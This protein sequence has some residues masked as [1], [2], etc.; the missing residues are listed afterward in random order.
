M[1]VVLR[2]SHL[3]SHI[4][5]ASAHLPFSIPKYTHLQI[6]A[7]LSP[8][9]TLFPEILQL[10][11]RNSSSS[12][13][14]GC[15]IIDQF[16]PSTDQCSLQINPIERHEVI[17]SLLKTIKRGQCTSLK[18]FLSL[19]SLSSLVKIMKSFGNCRSAVLFFKF[20]LP[21]SSEAFIRSSCIVALLLA[22]DS[23]RSLAQD[24]ISCVIT[25]IGQNRGSEVLDLMWRDHRAYVTEFCVLDIVFRAFLHAGAVSSAMQVLTRIR[26]RGLKP[27]ASSISILIKLLY[28]RGEFSTVW[29]LFRDMLRKGPR[30]SNRTFNTMVLGFCRRGDIRRGESLLQVMCKFGCKP[31]IYT[32]NIVINAHCVYGRSSDAFELLNSMIDMRCSPNTVTFNTLLKALCKEGNMQEAR[33]FFKEMCEEGIAPNQFAYNILIDGYAKAGEMDVANLVYVEMK[34]KGFTPDC[35]T[36]NILVS[37]HCKF[38]KQEDGDRLLQDVLVTDVLPDHSALDLFITRLCW[39]G[40]LDDAVGLLLHKIK[41]DLGLYLQLQRAIPCSWAYVREEDCK[42]L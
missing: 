16:L 23:L 26:E 11:A 40:R 30:P 20:A 2:R 4:W 39:E 22:V 42:R 9:K 29:D 31:D 25:R 12:S 35:F 41:K 14:S 3:S 13:G 38:G 37:G 10:H 15:H 19:N 5:C 33:R 28:Q 36:L 8:N 34:E 27:G 18:A 6:L 1:S 21:G 24:I 17:I 7:F 32:Y